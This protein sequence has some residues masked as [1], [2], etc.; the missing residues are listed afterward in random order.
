MIPVTSAPAML[1]ATRV[2]RL[3]CAPSERSTGG[4]TTERTGISCERSSRTT[5]S[6][7][8]ANAASCCWAATSVERY[9]DA[10]SAKPTETTT[11]ATATAA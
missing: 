4:V 8:T 9:E 11:N 7:G 2:T 3:T 10:N 5:S 6:A 1:P